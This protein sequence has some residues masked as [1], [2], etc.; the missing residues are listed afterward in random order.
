[1]ERAATLEL[2]D[3]FHLLD[4]QPGRCVDPHGTEHRDLLGGIGIEQLDE[5]VARQQRLALGRSGMRL[6]G[7]E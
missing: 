7:Q 1:V 4:V 2:F 6:L 3:V 5:R